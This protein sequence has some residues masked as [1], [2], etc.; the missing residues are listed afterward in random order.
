[1][2]MQRLDRDAL[3]LLS[4]TGLLHL[5]GFFSAAECQLLVHE[6]QQ[7]MSDASLMSPRDE[8]F[9][10]RY[11]ADNATFVNRHDR[12]EFLASLA[13]GPR[14][15]AL[16]MQLFPEGGAF[17]MSLVQ[18]SE[19]GRGQGI[20]W[21]QDVDPDQHTGALYNF[22]VYPEA[23]TLES[24]PLVYVPASHARGVLPPGGHYEEIA[25]QRALVAG[26]GDLV[27]AHAT[28]FHCV[29][30]N[31]T[32]RRR[33]SLNFRF[34]DARIPGSAMTVGVYRNGKFDYGAGAPVEQAS[35]APSGPATPSR[36]SRLLEAERAHL[37]TGMTPGF[38]AAPRVFSHG[39]GT[40]LYDVD[41]REYLDFSA[42][43]F[44]N[45]TGHCH[46]RVVSFLKDRVGELWNIHDYASPYRASLLQQLDA[47]TPPQIDTFEMYS[48]GTETVEAGLRALYSAMPEG[49]KGLCTFRQGFH[50]KTSGAR[51]L[52][53]WAMPGETPPPATLLDFPNCYR[54]PFGQKPESCQRQCEAQ[55][56]Q[57]L[58]ANPQLGALVIEPILGAGGAVSPP[59]GYLERLE[60]RCKERGLLI[61]LDEIC[62]GFGRTG[63]DFAFQHYGLTPDLM[64]FAKGLASGFPAMVL[65][66]RR[67][68]MTRPPFGNPGGASTTF[69]GNPLAI[70]AAHVT[71]EV[72]RDE[73]LCQNAAALEPILLARLDELAGRFAAVGQVRGRGL[74]A[75]LDFVKDRDG[76]APDDAF[77]LA[78]HRRC[79]ELGLKTFAFGHLFRVAPPLTISEGELHAGLDVIERALG[80]LLD[81]RVA[82]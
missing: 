55:V 71:L 8:Q 11:G 67:E 24:G 34:R 5:P 48:G 21:H 17:H 64:A 73:R 28:L 32:G 66:G 9:Y 25:G 33:F 77:G 76:K 49:K 31:Q 70:A 42:G 6:A 56:E 12:G 72:Y 75:C 68:L 82:A 19:A 36:M 43:T 22:L 51:G 15:G 62:V 79:M 3:D 1:M 53:G 46:P 18:L 2:M 38:L 57:T 13:H 45:S 27:I 60:A 40:K 80:E 63:R 47:L 50:G 26:A 14:L 39:R 81:A 4:T 65:G 37:P 58:D 54:C 7:V 10:A 61:F 16:A 23:L 59:P 52:V 78:V 29:P 30:R 41:G 20:S 35:S 69:G 74:F 44:T